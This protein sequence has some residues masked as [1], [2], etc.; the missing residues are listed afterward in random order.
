MHNFVFPIIIVVF[1]YPNIIHGK[2]YFH[3][4]IQK[5]FGCFILIYC[6]SFEIQIQGLFGTASCNSASSQN[7]FSSSASIRNAFVG[8]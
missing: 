5:L 4:E 8:I 7:V 3:F 6:K 2:T 1:V